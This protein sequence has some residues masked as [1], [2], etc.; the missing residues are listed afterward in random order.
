M[1]VSILPLVRL[2]LT[3]QVGWR[4]AERLRARFGG[5]DAVFRASEAALREIRGVGPVLARKILDASLEDRAK[6]EIDLARKS[7]WE[8][9]T[10]GIAPYPALLEETY[11]PP[12]ILWRKGELHP[13]D[14]RALAIVGARR[15]TSYGKRQAERFAAE[16]ADSGWTIVS[17]LARGIDTAAH[18]GCLRGGGRTIAVLGTGLDVPYPEENAGLLQEIASRGAVLTEFPSGTPPLRENF[19]RRNRVISGLARGT[20]VVEA[21]ERSGALI[22]ARW[23][24]EENRDVFALP[25]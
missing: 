25:G 24:T 16:L 8:I 7:G 15:A 20:I 22:T 3:G 18:S 14:E 17:G 23:A 5:V 2:S 9:D 11:D 6:R 12:L 19:P 10:P 4:Q 21:S 1:A 13:D